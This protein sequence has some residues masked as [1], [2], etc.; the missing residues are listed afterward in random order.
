MFVEWGC[1]S[2]N[3]GTISIH[4]LKGLASGYRYKVYIISV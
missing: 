4:L 2:T 1:I 3:I